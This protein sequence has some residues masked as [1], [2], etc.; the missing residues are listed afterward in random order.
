MS[1]IPWPEESEC[2]S[3]AA[4]SAVDELLCFDPSERPALA[5]LRTMPLFTSLDWERLLEQPGPFV[6]APDDATDTTYF[7]REYR[8]PAGRLIW[9]TVNTVS[10]VSCTVISA[11]VVEHSRE[12][13]YN[14]VSSAASCRLEIC[15]PDTI[16]L[17]GQL[18]V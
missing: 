13:G 14:L 4:V 9:A 17:L 3:P 11:A 16:I 8:Q 15:H 5:Q 2:F 12:Y 18:S 6:P 10:L 7:D 1:D